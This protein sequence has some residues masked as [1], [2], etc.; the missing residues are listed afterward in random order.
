ME[1]GRDR[2]RDGYLWKQ[3]K[4]CSHKCL[5]S[6]CSLQG[7]VQCCLFSF[8][9]AVKICVCTPALPHSLLIF[10]YLQLVITTPFPPGCPVF[11]LVCMFA[12]ISFGFCIRWIVN[13]I[14]IGMHICV[15]FLVDADFQLFFCFVLSLACLFWLI[16]IYFLTNTKEKKTLLLV[17]IV[18]NL[19]PCSHRPAIQ[20]SNRWNGRNLIFKVKTLL[21]ASV[22]QRASGRGFFLASCLQRLP[23]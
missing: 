13:I 2:P 22:H 21:F 3:I 16:Y 19:M 5:S 8:T 9:H 7:C 17:L 14:Q 6:L 4:Q 15:L 23:P 20:G 18:F 11:I 1:Q 12:E 10:L